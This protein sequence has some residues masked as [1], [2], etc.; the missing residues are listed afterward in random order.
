MGD[1]DR[2]ADQWRWASFEPFEL[3][4]KF[5]VVLAQDEAEYHRYLPPAGPVA[6]NVS[7]QVSGFRLQQEK[8]REIQDR[9]QGI[10]ELMGNTGDERAEP[11][12]RELAHQIALLIGH[13]RAAVDRDR[14]TTVFGLDT[15]IALSY[16]QLFAAVVTIRA[17]RIA[18]GREKR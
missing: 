15:G 7:V 14:V 12:A 11:D 6:G 8:L 16:K 17:R 3:D 1:W 10:V 9:L 5:L 4:P 2:H 18:H 13:R